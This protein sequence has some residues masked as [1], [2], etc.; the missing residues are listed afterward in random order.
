MLESEGVRR[1][2]TRRCWREKGV[3][4]ATH[5]R[6]D[7]IRWFGASRPSLDRP[8]FPAPGA[9]DSP[10]AGAAATPAGW[11]AIPNSHGPDSAGTPAR[12]LSTRVADDCR[13]EFDLGRHS[14]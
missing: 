11:P 5:S 4:Y 13:P 6:V 1:A 8:N 7:G 10:E 2:Q 12:E 9:K 14:A 3:F